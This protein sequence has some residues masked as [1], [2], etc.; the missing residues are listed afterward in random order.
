MLSQKPWTFEAVLRLILWLFLCTLGGNIIAQLTHLD[1]S[2]SIWPALIMVASVQGA[3]LVLVYFLLRRFD[4]SWREAFGL[5][6][7]PGRALGMGV[8]AALLFLP[9]GWMVQYGVAQLMDYLNLS[10]V[11]QS[12][13]ETL[14]VAS[15]WWRRGILAAAMIGLAPVAEEC[16]F[17]GILYP[18]VK[19]S[20]YPRAAFF[21]VSLLF[22]TAHFNLAILPPLF[23]LGML[24]TLL[25][26]RT[27]NLLAPI[28]AHATFNALNFLLFYLSPWL[29]QK[30]PGLGP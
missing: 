17:R 3:V 10:P 12:A 23:V 30:F 29:K 2:E 16:L 15:G 20:G 25:Y 6:D 24:L 22:A 28:T 21:G 19:Q 4:L 5:A 27:N 7:Q 11:E 8:V 9:I 13:V 18:L 26:E 14:D 1:I